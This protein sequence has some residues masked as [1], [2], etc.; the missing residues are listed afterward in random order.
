MML[1]MW[2]FRLLFS[3]G[4]GIFT[5][6]S[7]LVETGDTI[8]GKVLTDVCCPQIN[9]F[10]DIVFRGLFSGGAGIFTQSNL[11]VQNGDTI[12]GRMLSSVG[13]FTSLNDI[14]NVVFQGG[15]PSGNGIYTPTTIL[16][17]SGD[18]IGGQVLVQPLS[19]RPKLNNNNDVAFKSTITGPPPVA[20]AIFTLSS[21]VAKTGDTIDGKTL[22]Q[23]FTPS[24]NDNGDIVFFGLFSGNRGIFT[25]TTL[26]VETGDTIAGKTLT[27]I[28]NPSNNNN[29]DV[30]YIGDFAGG[31]GVFTPTSLLIQSGAT[32]DGVT[33]VSFFDPPII[34]DLGEVLGEVALSPSGTGIILGTPIASNPFITIN[35]PQPNEIFNTDTPNF[36]FSVSNPSLPVDRILATVDNT[37]TIVDDLFPGGAFGNI[38]YAITS[39]VPLSEG[40]HFFSVL[41]DA[42]YGSV[43]QQ[44]DFSI[45]AD[46]DD[47]NDGIF[48]NLDSTP[49]VFSDGF[50]DVPLGGTTFGTILDRGN[51]F[52][53]IFEL[54]NPDGVRIMG[55][56]IDAFPGTAS[57]ETCSPPTP[58]SVTDGDDFTVFC[59]STSLTVLIGPVEA[60]FEAID[61]T[62]AMV[63][64][65]DGDTVNYDSETSDIIADDSNVGQISVIIDGQE[66]FLAA[67][68]ASSVDPVQSTQILIEDIKNLG[69]KK[70]NE[71]SLTGKLDNVVKKLSDNKPKNDLGSCDRLDE[72]IDEVNSQEGRSLT[73]LQADEL[74]DSVQPIKN[75]IGCP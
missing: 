55:S 26:L 48:D 72:F 58:I 1:V 46:P 54:P 29:N 44:V 37:I 36:F 7:L 67:G 45:D 8:D 18:T 43:N 68:E 39:P 12:G 63:I 16:A 61:G 3:G 62:I 59:G 42:P 24:L 60:E 70:G 19:N 2:F 21:V 4:K 17:E 75:G 41:M 20:N 65:N 50:S 52:L 74:R 32:I 57:L 11:L 53:T 34:N 56:A 49:S 69:L 66:S 23:V 28:G 73:T 38:N 33:I 64:V 14:G 30:V 71:K 51:L 10:G 40:P 47:D 5:P 9:N 13:P 6:S 25:P 35:S 15:F 27:L 22:D 31:D